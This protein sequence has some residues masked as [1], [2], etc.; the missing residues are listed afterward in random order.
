[1]STDAQIQSCTYCDATSYWKKLGKVKARADELKSQSKYHQLYS[2]IDAIENELSKMHP[3]DDYAGFTDKVTEMKAK[4]AELK[5]L[6][7]L[8]DPEDPI[9][10]ERKGLLDL[11]ESM[12][13]IMYQCGPPCN[14]CFERW[15]KHCDR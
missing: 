15:K 14:Q 7:Q 9:E 10:K 13:H 8:D 1:M 6:R 11:I 5:R 2:E 12:H 3:K 4:K